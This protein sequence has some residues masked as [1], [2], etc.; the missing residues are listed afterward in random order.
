MKEVQGE[1]EANCLHVGPL[2]GGGD[3]HVHV[4]E[5]GHNN[6]YS[7]QPGAAYIIQYTF[8]HIIWGYEMLI[9]QLQQ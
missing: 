2:E 5:P 9:E 8:I 6:R 7:G 1:L 4:Q 3:V